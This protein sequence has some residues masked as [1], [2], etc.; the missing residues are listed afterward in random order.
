MGKGDKR[1]IGQ[2]GDGGKLCLDSFFVY[3]VF[4][5]INIFDFD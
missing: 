5:F 1:G 3:Q 2:R 4:V